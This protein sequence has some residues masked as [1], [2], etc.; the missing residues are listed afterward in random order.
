VVAGRVELF[1]SSNR[2][3][4]WSVWHSAFDAAAATWAAPDPVTAGPFTERGPAPLPSPAGLW[5]FS[6]SNRPV[7]YTSQVYRATRTVDRRYSGSTTVDTRNAAKLALHGHLDDFATY[8]YATG[9]D[10]RPTDDDRYAYDAVGVFLDPAIDLPRQAGRS[11][12]L[13]QVKQSLRGFVPVQV[14][15]ILIDSPS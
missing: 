7:T 1:W 13:E 15:V 2:A 6:G 4:A 3:G 9:R 14:R 11:A 12:R 10:G 5:L 8:S